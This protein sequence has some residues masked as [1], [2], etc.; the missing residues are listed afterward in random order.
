MTSGS[1]TLFGAGVELRGRR[2][3]RSSRPSDWHEPVPARH[4]GSAFAAM[5]IPAKNAAPSVDT[6]AAAIKLRNLVR[7]LHFAL[8]GKPSHNELFK[9][10]P[11]A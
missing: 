6:A 7:I 4:T 8:E 1:V 5:A 11:D 3:A 2:A 10:T 9:S